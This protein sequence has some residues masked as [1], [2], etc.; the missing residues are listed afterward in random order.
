M[1]PTDPD[2]I[3]GSVAQLGDHASATVTR[4]GKVIG[5]SESQGRGRA[6]S[7]DVHESGRVTIGICG[8]PPRGEEGTIEACHRLIMQRNLALG[9]TWE[10]PREVRGVQYIDAEVLGSGSFAGRRM[11]IQ[12]VRALTDPSFWKTLGYAGR[13]SLDLSQDEAAEVLKNA[14]EFKASKIPLGVRSSLTLALDATDVP[15]LSMHA[16]VDSFNSLHGSWLDAQG[17]ESVWV[18]G[19]WREMVSRLGV[20]KG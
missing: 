11:T 7:G 9:E 13:E 20:A 3:L 19:P 1:S 12:V 16:V 17:F 5:F 2:E 6:A 8:S 18:V 4:K 14:I 15:A 10:E